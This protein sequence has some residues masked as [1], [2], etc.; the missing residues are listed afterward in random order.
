[1]GSG[2]AGRNADTAVSTRLHSRAIQRRRY[3]QGIQSGS[4][5]GLDFDSRGGLPRQWTDRNEF[6]AAIVP[7]CRESPGRVQAGGRLKAAL[8]ISQARFLVPAESPKRR[9][10]SWSDERPT[11][12]QYG[13]GARAPAGHTA[14][15]TSAAA[16]PPA[17]AEGLAG[18]CGSRCTSVGQHY[19]GRR[20]PNRSGGTNLGCSLLSPILRLNPP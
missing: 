12:G 5:V 2:A 18:R 19:D 4:W 7:E 15:R 8:A 16:G 17:F 9:G 1:M 3:T 20:F 13:P 11:R 10:R 14:C 6:L